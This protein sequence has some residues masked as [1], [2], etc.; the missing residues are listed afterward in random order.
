MA[1]LCWSELIRTGDAAVVG[2][3]DVHRRRFAS[4]AHSNEGA[5]VLYLRIVELV[6][7]LACIFDLS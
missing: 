2:R 6:L 5:I 1:C 3:G 7:I 4:Q